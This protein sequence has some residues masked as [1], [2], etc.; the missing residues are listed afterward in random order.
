MTKVKIINEITM[1][2]IKE[3]LYDNIHIANA[4]AIA[5]RE[6]LPTGEIVVIDYNN[7]FKLKE[8]KSNGN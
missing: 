7:P 3:F 8:N 6:V 5:L 4:V 2:T 1:T